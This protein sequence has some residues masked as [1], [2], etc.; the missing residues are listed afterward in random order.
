MTHVCA[1]QR[2]VMSTCE[3]LGPPAEGGGAS[4]LEDE[5]VLDFPAVL[6]AD[7]GLAAR[8]A[9]DAGPMRLVIRA[10]AVVVAEADERRPGLAPILAPALLFPAPPLAGVDL[11]RDPLP[12]RLRLLTMLRMHRAADPFRPV[13]L[14]GPA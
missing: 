1:L 9:L 10:L 14:L 3:R 8:D 11:G 2:L 6:R 4:A 12:E 5:A 13:L 7:A